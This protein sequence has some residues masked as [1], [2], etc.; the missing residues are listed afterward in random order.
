MT[1]SFHRNIFSPMYR[2]RR[3]G[4][5]STANP[6]SS[7]ATSPSALTA[8]TWSSITIPAVTAAAPN[9]QTVNKEIWVDKRRAE[10]ID[11]LISMWYSHF[12][13]NSI[14]WHTATRN[15]SM[16]FFTDAALKRFSNYL[17]IRN[18]SVQHPVLSRSF[19][20]GTRRLITMCICTVS[21][22]AED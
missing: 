4:L 3:H 2:G 12:H 14:S 16:G 11:A 9:C 10:V 7:A 1:A 21:S 13:M 8:G 19:T 20:P 5:S 18:I 6:A 22:L 17:L 15:S